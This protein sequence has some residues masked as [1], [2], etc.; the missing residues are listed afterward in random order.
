LN[1][2]RHAY[3]VCFASMVKQFHQA[4]DLLHRAVDVFA[5]WSFFTC[6]FAVSIDLADICARSCSGMTV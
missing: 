4:G 1:V 6:G 5:R 3:E 2:L